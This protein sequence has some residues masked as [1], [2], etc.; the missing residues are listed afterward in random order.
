MYFVHNPSPSTFVSLIFSSYFFGVSGVSYIKSYWQALDRTRAHIFACTHMHKHKDF[1]HQHARSHHHIK[2]NCSAYLS[3]K[4]FCLTLTRMCPP[5]FVNYIVWNEIFRRTLTII[6]LSFLS[7]VLP[8]T[9]SHFRDKFVRT[10][11]HIHIFYIILEKRACD[12]N[13]I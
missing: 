4:L 2:K 5:H 12:I 11:T 7:S 1:L 6:K 3:A 13:S 9:H 8:Q 10:R